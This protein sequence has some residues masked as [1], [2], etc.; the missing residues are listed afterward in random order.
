MKNIKVCKK[1]CLLQTVQC[2]GRAL[3]ILWLKALSDEPD[4]M[5]SN[6]ASFYETS[7]FRQFLT[8]KYSQ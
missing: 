5:L 1:L 7:Q 8:S 6:K 3:F 4:K 2:V